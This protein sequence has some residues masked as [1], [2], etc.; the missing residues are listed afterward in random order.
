[1][2]SAQLEAAVE[3]IL[4]T[5]SKTES[6]SFPTFMQDPMIKQLES[7]G[8]KVI[9]QF[10][11]SFSPT[12]EFNALNMGGI[13]SAFSSDTLAIALGVVMSSTVAGLI[14]RFIPFGN[15]TTIIAGLV[16]TMVFKQGF[17]HGFAKGVL[18]A[19]IASI[20]SGLGG[21]LGGLLGGASSG[22]AAANPVLAG[23]QF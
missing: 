16:L 20:F 11:Q 3:K 21:S 15:L 18:I 4:S 12:M 19:G 23:V 9:P 22:A 2:T 17:M 1:M 14:G 5:S 6:A 10:N 13:K 8:Y 7:M